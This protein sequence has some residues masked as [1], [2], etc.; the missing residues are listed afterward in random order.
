MKAIKTGAK[1]LKR[2]QLTAAF[3][4][5]ESV[6]IRITNSQALRSLREFFLF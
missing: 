4:A 5:L 1:R 2:V 6:F 3:S